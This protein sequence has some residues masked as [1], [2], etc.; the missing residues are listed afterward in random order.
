MD[1]EFEAA[2][3]NP[4]AWSA[5][6]VSCDSFVL[7]FDDDASAMSQPGTHPGMP[8]ALTLAASGLAIFCHASDDFS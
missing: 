1:W 4:P 5:T 2:G 6:C 3:T 8:A 7:F